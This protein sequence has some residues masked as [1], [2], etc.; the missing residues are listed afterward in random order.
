MTE[1]GFTVRDMGFM[2]SAF[3]L[4]FSVAKVFG[5]VASDQFS[6]R[7]LMFYSLFFA[8]NLFTLTI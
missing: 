8:G 3:A 1:K 6:P 4:S 7:I 5:G 2:A